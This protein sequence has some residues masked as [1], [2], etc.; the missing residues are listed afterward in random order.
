MTERWSCVDA[1]EIGSGLIEN[2]LVL[3]GSRGRR[4]RKYLMESVAGEGTWGEV[5]EAS[6]RATSRIARTLK[7]NP[8]RKGAARQGCDK[9]DER[10]SQHLRL[11]FVWENEEDAVKAGEV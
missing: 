3:K 10:G 7:M 2:T 1:G 9:L 6:D 8:A 4:T 5:T 11:D